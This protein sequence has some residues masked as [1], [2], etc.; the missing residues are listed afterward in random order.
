[1][2]YHESLLLSLLGLAT[3][4]FSGASSQIIGSLA[5]LIYTNKI[6][7]ETM[8]NIEELIPH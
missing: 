3:D 2:K 6:N 8:K 5:N 7:K 4:P 1:L